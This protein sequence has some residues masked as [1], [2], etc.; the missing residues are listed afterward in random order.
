VGKQRRIL[1]KNH[2]GKERGGFSPFNLV[3]ELDDEV[4]EVKSTTEWKEGFAV[5]KKK[6]GDS[7]KG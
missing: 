4:V 6:K 3:G 5:K 2:L 7:E 1:R